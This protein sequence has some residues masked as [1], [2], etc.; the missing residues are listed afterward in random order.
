MTIT[1]VA[2]TTLFLRTEM[3][4]NSLNDGDV[5]MGALFFGLTTFMFNALPEVAVTVA[6]LPVFYKQR[7]LL[8]YPAWAYSLPIWILRIPLSFALLAPWSII[9]YYGMGFDPNAKR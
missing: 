4:R 9:C 2:V 5:F 1:S 3:H 6:K 7:D 8:F